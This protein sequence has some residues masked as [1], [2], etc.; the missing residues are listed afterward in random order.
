MVRRRFISTIS[1]VYLMGCSSQD[2][3]IKRFEPSNNFRS[4]AN[5]E[6]ILSQEEL[7]LHTCFNTAKDN[8]FNQFPFEEY[9]KESENNK[10][11]FHACVLDESIICAYQTS[12]LKI[13]NQIN[14]LKKEYSIKGNKQYLE[15]TKLREYDPKKMI[16]LKF[17]LEKIFHIF[18]EKQ[19]VNAFSIDNRDFVS[20]PIG[21]N[22]IALNSP[23]SLDLYCR[24]KL[25]QD[26]ELAN[27]S[28]NYYKGDECPEQ[29]NLN[30]QNILLI[31]D[32]GGEIIVGF[33]FGKFATYLRDNEINL[34]QA[35]SELNTLAKNKINLSVEL[36]MANQILDA[37]PRIISESLKALDGN[38]IAR[39]SS[40]GEYQ[41]LNKL[42]SALHISLNECVL[43]TIPKNKKD[44]DQIR[45]GIYIV[46][47]QK[48]GQIGK[49]IEEMSANKSHIGLL[50][51]FLLDAEN[52]IDIKNLASQSLKF[53]RI[54][55]SNCSEK[56]I[57]ELNESFIEEEI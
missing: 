2:D 22:G 21:V 57:I 36:I 35:Q 48:F 15:W 53:E 31:L 49:S 41:E 34:S 17:D 32:G 8:C 13:V 6:T 30:G 12:D 42:V 51:P 18:N 25:V 3:R 10:E 5:I 38:N 16:D 26:L 33:N 39:T 19:D 9:D 37:S 40:V 24:S 1:F 29:I 55:K 52:L 45:P 14:F 44:G 56:S 46:N 11:E 27:L 20:I 50:H 7:Q 28:R 23:K 47:F 43:H 54:I 4:I